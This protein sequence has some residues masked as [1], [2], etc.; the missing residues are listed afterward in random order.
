[1]RTSLR[2]LLG[3]GVGAAAI[4][5]SGSAAEAALMFDVR[6][7][8]GGKNAVVAAPGEVVNLEIYAVVTGATSAA[9]SGFQSA[10]GGLRS[11]NG[12][13]LGNLVHT[14]DPDFGSTGSAAGNLV[15]VDGDSDNDIG[16]AGAILNTSAGKI[17][18]RAAFMVPGLENLIG[19]ATF[20]VGASLTGSTDVNFVVAGSTAFDK[21]PLWSEDGVAKNAT[22]G[23][24]SVG[25]PVTISAVPEPASLG[26]LAV[27]AMGLLARRRRA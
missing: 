7:A 23:T 9:T 11:S 27:G 16:P 2:T 15:D 12:G 26:L 19:T 13:L 14:L 20:T 4:G 22:T 25:S 1:M 3:L 21:N 24:V 10:A 6:V 17:S 8:G 18:Y 5:M